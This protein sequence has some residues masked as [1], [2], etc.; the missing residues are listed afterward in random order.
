MAVSRP[1]AII[2]SRETTNLFGFAG[3]NPVSRFDAV[4]TQSTVVTDERPPNLVQGAPTEF[5]FSHYD[6]M[7]DIAPPEPLFTIE[8]PPNPYEEVLYNHPLGGG[9]VQTRAQMEKEKRA[10]AI[11][12]WAYGIRASANSPVSAAL[13]SMEGNVNS[14]GAVVAAAMGEF[15]WNMASFGGSLRIGP[16]RGSFNGADVDDRTYNYRD[17]LGA[18]LAGASALRSGIGGP[19]K[20][21]PRHDLRGSSGRYV[22]QAQYE[23]QVPL[24][25][26]R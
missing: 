18:E 3:G 2:A 10:A 25:W 20:A 1:D 16:G 5:D 6:A 4:G 11:A 19:A 7:W 8:R 12:A 21:H 15:V 23:L 26:R 24:Y 14:E 9:I 22:N 17:V 13:T